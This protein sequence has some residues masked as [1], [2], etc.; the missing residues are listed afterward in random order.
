MDENALDGGLVHFYTAGAA[1]DSWI[2]VPITSTDVDE[3][4]IQLYF[5]N[6]LSDGRYKVVFDGALTSSSGKSLGSEQS[7]EFT[8][9]A[10]E[11]IIRTEEWIGIEHQGKHLVVDG[12][13]VYL[14]GE[15]DFSSVRVRN[16]GVITVHSPSGLQLSAD[17]IHIDATSRIDATGQ[18]QG[19][20]ATDVGN[21]SGGSHGGKGGVATNQSTN[22]P[23]GDFRE[24][25]DPGTGGRGTGTN[26]IYGGGVLELITPK[27]TVEG[28]LQAN[29]QSYN[30]YGTG[31]GG[32]ILLRADTLTIGAQ[33]SIEANGGSP[34][35]RTGRGTGSGGR[36]AVYSKTSDR[37]ALIKALK[38]KGGSNSGGNNGAAG[39]LYLK[40]T[41]T[42][43]SELIVDNSGVE[44]GTVATT[45]LDLPG[46]GEPTA[47]LT[48]I[49]ARVELVDTAIGELLLTNSVVN[50]AVDSITTLQATNSQVTQARA[51]Q[52]TDLRINKGAWIQGGFALTADRHQFL[53][54][55]L[56]MSGPFNGL[57]GPDLL[58]DG[59]TLV[60]HQS[61][62]WNKVRVLNGGVITTPEASDSFSQG[63]GITADVLEV[64]ATS[65]I[66]VSAKGDL[67]TSAM[68]AYAGGSHGGWGGIYG[69]GGGNGIHGDFRQ[70]VDFGS[71]GRDGGNGFSR[72]GG[73]LTVTAKLLKLEGQLLANGQ[74]AESFGSGSGGSLW[75]RVEAL[76]LGAAARIHANAGA[77][78]IC[79]SVGGG[80]GGRI[81]VEYRALD[82]TALLA[83]LQAKGA[84]GIRA[85]SGAAGTLFLHD[86][87]SDQSEL[88]IDNSGLDKAQSAKTVLDL[89]ISGELSSKLTVINA[90]VEIIGAKL[91][92]VVFRDSV[93]SLNVAQIAHLQAS[94]SQLTQA[95]E[96]HALKLNLS[97]STWRQ[98][99]F[100]LTA[101]SYSL[102]GGSTLDMSGVFNAASDELL[103]DGFTLEL[104]KD[105]QIAKIRVINSGVLS[106]RPVVSGATQ[107]ITLSA[108]EILV[109]AT[110]RIDVSGKGLLAPDSM[111]SRCGAS[112]GGLGGAPYCVPNPV[113]GE[114]LTP[115]SLG[116]GGGTYGT[117]V[118][119]GGG[120]LKLVT[121][122]LQIDGQLLADG[123]GIGGWSSTGAGAGGSLW[124]EAQLIA[125][126]A[127]TRIF[128]RGG[129]ARDNASGG[130]GGGGRIAI[131]YAGLQG[132]D[133]LSQISVNGGV[134]VNGF[135]GGA[136]SL[137]LENRVVATAV[138]GTNLEAVTGREVSEFTVDFINAVLPDSVTAEQVKLEG[139]LGPVSLTTI[140]ALNTVRYQFTLATPL[141]DGAYT[142]RV[143]PGIRSAQ[144]HGMDQNGNGIENEPDDVFT[145][146]FVVDR[147]A[148]DAPVVTQ[149]AVA[150]AINSLTLR[151]VDI[152]GERE[153]DTAILIDGEVQ[154]A[155]GSGAWVLDNYELVEGDSELQVQ[156]RDLAG[157]LSPA[158]LL[159]FSVDSVA[160]SIQGVVP[161]G[162]IRVAPEL[163]SVKFLETGTGLDLANSLLL[164]KHGGNSLS[165]E[166]SLEGDTL[167][168]RPNATL[169]AGPYTLEVRLQDKAANK[170]V[171]NFSFDLDYIA[172][173]APVVDGY[174]AVTANVVFRLSGLKE[175]GSLLQLL[176][177]AGNVLSAQNG[178][179]TH[180]VFFRALVPGD[181]QFRLTQT[182]AAGNQSPEVL[183]NVR[184]DNEA[185]GLVGFTIDPNGSGT[186]LAFSWPD[187]NE[188][189]N[190]N[191]IKQ[192]VLYGAAQPFTLLSQAQPLLRVGAGVKEALLKNLPRGV[193]GHYA[194]VAEDQQGLAVGSVQ[195][196]AATPVDKQAPEEVGGL[197][198]V[199]GADFLQL[200]WQT[201]ANLAGDLAGYALYVGETDPQRIDLP[202]AGL[203]AGLV[204]RLEGLSPA[205]ANPLRLVALDTTGNESAGVRNPGITW[206]D[207]PQGLELKPQ[208]NRFEAQWTAVQPA[209]WVGGYR[210]Y[211]ADAPFTSIVGLKPK[212]MTSA[213]QASA[214]VAGL[215]N[216]KT[217][218]VAVTVVNA[219]GGENP[220]VQS[221]SVTPVLDSEGPELL[222]LGWKSAELEQDLLQGG[223]LQQIGEWR[224]QA[225]DQSGIGR[226]ELSL[227]G[228]PL[229]QANQVDADYRYA[230]D[231]SSVVDGEYQLGIKLYDTLDNF[232]ESSVT[233]QVNLAAPGKPSLSLHNPLS[234]TNE[235]QQR[236][237]IVG[238]A[239]TLAKVL[240]NGATYAEAVRLDGSGRAELPV[241]LVQGNNQLRANL[242]YANRELFGPQSEPLQIVLDSALPNAPGNLQALSKPLGQVQLNWS[243]TPSVAGYDLY[244][245][246]QPFAA[247]SAGGVAKV[248]DKPLTAT[249]Y[250]H[251]PT[252]D[253]TYYYR[254]A[255]VKAGGVQ[256]ALSMQKSAVADRLAPKV[257]RILYTT[258]GQ[259]AEDGRH[260]PASVDVRLQVSEPLRNAPFFSLDVPQGASIALR[261]TAVAN[262][263]KVYQGRFDLGANIPSGQLYART[264][265]FDA[266]G[267]EGSEVLEGK[268]LPVDTRGPELQQLS[269]L[270]EHPVKNLLVDDQGR[271]L[272]VVLRLNEE[273]VEPPQLVPHLDGLPLATQPAAIALLKDDQSQPG[274]PVYTGRFRLPAEAGKTKAQLLGF[275]YEARDD[276]GN[277]SKRIQGR[278]EFQ[279]YQ[280]DL[281]PLDMPQGLTG[282]ALAAGRVA[283]QWRAV[284]EASAY[285][286]YRRAA[287]DSSFAPIGRVREL[288]F[289][290]NLPAAGLGDGRY[291]YRVASIRE[292]E[293]TEVLG[294][295]SEA[296]EVQVVSQAPSAP[297][298][299]AVELNG[300]GVV[301]RWQPPVEG[302]T[303]T[304]NLYRANVGQG[305]PVE[306]DGLTPLWSKIAGLV[307]L[308]NKPSD[309]EHAYTVTAVDAAGNESAPATSAYLNA[310]LL[311][312]RDLAI[313]LIEGQPPRLKWDHNGKDVVGY[314]LYLGTPPQKLNLA[315]LTEKSFVDT[316]VVLPVTSERD[317]SVTA[318]DAQGVESLPHRLLLPALKA[319][320]RADQVFQR[321]LFNALQYRVSNTGTQGVQRVRLRVEVDVAGKVKQHLSEAFDVAAGSVSEVPVIV[322]GYQQ[323]PGVVP[324]SATLVYAP[325]PG[326]E[327]TLQR[328]QS[329]NAGEGALLVQLLG[330]EFTRGGIGQV[331]LRL[332]NP[333]AVDTELVTALNNGKQASPEMRLI[334]EDLQGNVLATEP[335]NAAL[336][337]GL[338]TVRD[339][340][341][342]ARV[343]A[344]AVL[345][346]GPFNLPIPSGAPDQV[347]VRLQ[348]D[349]LH[350]QTGLSG[351]LQIGGLASSA[352][353]TLVEA[354]YYA[355]VESIVPQTLQAGDSVTIKGRA[356]TRADKTP[357]ANSELKLVVAGQGFEQVV[358]LTT[359]GDG[360]FEYRHASAST[361]AGEYQV[362]VV[363]PSIQTRPQQGRF[364]VQG[365]TYS[366]ARF[367]L[368]F[369][370]NYEQLATVTLEA[371]ADTPLRNLRLE[372]V[373]PEGVTGLPA[374]VKVLVGM[375]LNLAAKQRGSLTLRISADNN[376]APSGLLDYRIVAEG[377]SKPLGQTRIQ[378][379]LVD[380]RPMAKVSPLQ[381]QTGLER[382]SERVENLTLSNGGLDLLR[383]VRLS[384]LDE[385]GGPAPSWVSLRT[386]ERPGNLAVGATTPIAV[387]FRPSESVPEGDYFFTLRIES[388]NHPVVNIPMQAVLNQSGRGGVAFKVE[389]IYTGTLDGATRVL[390]LKGARIK[391]Q[392]R[393]VLSSEYSLTSDEQGLAHL[394]DIPAGEYSYRVS[395]WDHNDVSG[396]VWIKPGL[397]QAESVF[398]MNKLV[399]VEW[400]VREITLE[401]R[402][403]VV[404][405]ATFKTNVPSAVV[406]IEPLSI[407]LPKMRKGDV[408]QGE[409][410]LTNY[411]LV[412]ADNVRAKLPSGDA[413]AKL[414]YL[415]PVP[416]TL[417]SGDVVVVPYRVLALQSFDPDDPLNGAA[418]CW[419]FAYQGQVTYS[420]MCANGMV[421]P[422]SAGVAWSSSGT[423]CSTHS[424]NPSGPSGPWG[425][426]GGGGW[427]GS[428]GFIARPT[429]MGSAQQCTPP[430]DCETCNAKGGGFAG[431][432][433]SHGGGNSGGAQ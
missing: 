185:P 236:L 141:E 30:D 207:N 337:N 380:A 140:Q 272:Q 66:D 221:A 222:G 118:T 204:Y 55:S 376:A 384:L 294:L 49:D 95:G 190:G 359:D 40:N 411:G 10:K 244:V 429:G 44:Q 169:L 353:F 320:L 16:G 203:G 156:M 413:R 423:S 259:V 17:E 58:V 152:R 2:E 245:A 179:D 318:V 199:S 77:A 92:T 291:F 424:S 331:R 103:V 124:I 304:Y 354:P 21:Y 25:R 270:P 276:L 428:G 226:V 358:Q 344:K 277:I 78:S 345:E 343:G 399:T 340:R 186:E 216:D 285:Q 111:D 234:Q 256:S 121:R 7:H 339:G 368:A 83:A 257:E 238:Q 131:Y 45:R 258:Q 255:S 133:P 338:I 178:Y 109:D 412:R 32:S 383:N 317:Y 84:A 400:S 170:R 126:S 104:S 174:P 373:Q 61:G 144:G 18:G 177:G 74:A 212:L 53:G 261:M 81:A 419:A 145:L 194:V 57:T 305:E 356:L 43:Q 341:T 326:E 151:K 403:E 346:T 166:L 375:P 406:L 228:Q 147:Q 137:H 119:R 274:A 271:E 23:Y 307:V 97:A 287:T 290:D 65:R 184:F 136:G 386:S 46:N 232:S 231:V 355:E 88:V 188:A 288:A 90:N 322:A 214:V 281:P 273:P 364:L 63:I 253:G 388:D 72:G 278:R 52:V 154:V 38:A 237:I 164:L 269:L 69:N 377:L 282:K 311:P 370:R 193:L 410:T 218:H 108:D 168:L 20:D 347:R 247:T 31:S 200:N 381:L 80:S 85:Q 314:N 417:E 306:I 36:I 316:G 135:P 367:N 39:T 79:C 67:G 334:L 123:G 361:D 357:Q 91:G 86:L 51:L 132:F 56:D 198:V 299:L 29:G 421:V 213:A 402:Y 350:Y 398:L 329:Q 335:I 312:V 348:V 293:G 266:V 130:S 113:Y 225:K 64:D 98:G 210:V 139:P 102:L 28:R 313:S 303:Y 418:G 172:P 324:L 41:L 260:G 48:V 241:T 87:G 9:E 191:D 27:L 15:R 4:K 248:N 302:G 235:P 309:T 323:L 415:R 393:K 422:G 363:H 300:A 392:N 283:L 100:A 209:A 37:T 159:K 405:N 397:T 158:T 115:V 390:G 117:V 50:L 129:S 229:G 220:L 249:S 26:F 297:R 301:L 387:A 96:L 146:G 430:P 296:V 201:S 308:D 389:D 34:A 155:R 211:V 267:N 195:S 382:G 33:A 223:E 192:Y 176:D 262:E 325:Q 3:R 75:L 310:G 59:F 206:L 70:P 366:P 427:G 284:T 12:A 254:V 239:N 116:L 227:N 275:T 298:E 224:I 157:N 142:L 125:G 243:A 196:Q 1:A 332:E 143:G 246:K 351:E 352:E 181:N 160:P 385:Q 13:Q 379:T 122:S 250:L 315:P 336:G 11:L 112:H 99:G 371:G 89:G 328:N 208:A 372:Y 150:P 5:A 394:D 163:I 391:L 127:T 165:G 280:G 432:D 76:E 202:L 433:G 60:L 171:G 35:W 215:L 182:D 180:W 240:L 365:A 94:N 251:Q 173:A 360:A 105:I 148:T 416:D 19:Q 219:S 414:E 162:A 233:L 14:A 349:A 289:E 42:D 230:W 149:P 242:R 167:R 128:A 369:P 407:N 292:H 47:K 54:N 420:S 286:V 106:M 187:Y 183:V 404:L 374:G 73:A 205:S 189:A 134:S 110:S 425:W 68:G 175:S 153:D 82:K 409:L 93:A 120:A 378:Y 197:S 321:G 22:T 107:G 396:Q 24:P 342:V 431:G 101:D 268:T 327:V 71:G 362:S 263:P 265:L 330:D 401:D 295:P 264:L 217:Y 319:E 161:S 333:S 408:M 426:L 8:V 6:R 395:A 114:Y 279:V 252:E 138:A 62:T